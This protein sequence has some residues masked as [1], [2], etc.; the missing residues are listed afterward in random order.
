MLIKIQCWWKC[1]ADENAMLMEMQ[2]WWNG[3]NGG[4]WVCGDQ[5]DGNEM[6]GDEIS[7]DELSLSLNF[8]I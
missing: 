3:W 6:Y 1:N 7:G 4:L 2:C 5:M 8:L